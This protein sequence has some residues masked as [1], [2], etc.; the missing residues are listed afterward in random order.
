MNKSY[1][2]LLAS[3]SEAITLPKNKL[4]GLDKNKIKWA[5]ITTAGNDVPS[6]DYLERTEK[7]MT[8]L[9]WDVEEM[10]ITGKTE[11]QIY[12]MLKDKQ[13]IF[14]QGGNTYYLLKQINT[15]GFAKVLDKLLEQGIIYAGTSA[16]TYVMCP[17]IEMNLWKDADKF[18]KHGLTD[19]TAMGKIPFQIVCHYDRCSEEDKTNVQEKIKQSKY[20]VKILEDGQAILVDGDKISLIDNK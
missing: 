10:D 18:D 9:G 17:N 3:N 1:K 5:Y 11:D 7:Q 2:L 19:L 8:D 20:D 12:N 6:T 15:T 13:A 4:F 16:G 14:M